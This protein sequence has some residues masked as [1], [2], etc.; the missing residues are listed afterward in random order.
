M[1]IVDFYAMASD[2]MPTAGTPPHGLWA[3]L[4]ASFANGIVIEVGRKIRVPQAEESGV[5]TYS[6]LW[7]LPPP[8]VV[9]FLIISGYLP[10]SLPTHWGKPAIG[11][12]LWWRRPHRL[13]HRPAFSV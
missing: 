12:Y 3:F 10:A 13:T 11:P 8:G 6:K 1:P 9:D 7:G 4:I 5:P 2:W